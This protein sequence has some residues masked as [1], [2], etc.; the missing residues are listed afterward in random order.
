V[1]S[2]IIILLLAVSAGLMSCRSSRNAEAGAHIPN[3]KTDQLLGLMKNNELD[4]EWMSVKYDVE[5]KTSKIDDSFKAYARIRKD[6]AIWIS[7]TYYA[8]EVA[9]FLFTPDSVKY[10]DRKNNKYYVGDYSYITDRFMIE[11]NFNVL[12]SVIMAN[13]RSMV[14]ESEGKVR[15]NKDRGMY[16]IFFLRKGQMR[17]A[18]R[19][20]E[21]TLKSLN[22]DLWLD[23]ESFRTSKLT[24]T[25]IEEGRSFTATYSDFESSCSSLHPKTT[26]FVAIST[27]EQAEVKTSVMKRTTGK[28]VSLSFTIPEKYE[29]L[30]P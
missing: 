30:V 8:V 29:P 22:I 2:R 7:A 1:N 27:N 28:K 17:R 11:A 14:E 20:E 13:G 23:A 9:R 12:Q 10:I 4:C 15:S 26:E 16:H 6:S 18:Q 24:V 19:K 3:R 25:D 5:I 21:E